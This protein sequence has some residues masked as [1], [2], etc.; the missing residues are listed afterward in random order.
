VDTPQT[1]EEAETKSKTESE[2]GTWNVCFESL[3][4]A[5]VTETIGDNRED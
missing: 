5:T 4:S 2:R 1:V 3:Y